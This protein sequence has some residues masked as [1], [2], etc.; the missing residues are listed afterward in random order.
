[1][2]RVA[3]FTIGIILLAIAVMGFMPEFNHSGRILGFFAINSFSNLMHLA[4]G[5]I[6]LM[7]AIQG[8]PASSYFFIAIGIIY[9]VMALLGFWDATIALFHYIIAD[10]ANNIF[11]AI[12]A[13]IALYF[14]FSYFRKQS[15]R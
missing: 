11:H 4:T 1:M 2:V 13:A 8:R 9:A 15:L 6:A 7:C 3:A 5:I 10:G 12:I 14:G